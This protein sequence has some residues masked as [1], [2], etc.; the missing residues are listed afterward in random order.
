[1][2]VSASPSPA[3]KK[4]CSKGY[5]CSASCISRDKNCLS[6][7]AGD[8]SGFAGYLKRISGLAKLKTGLG[9]KIAQLRNKI[10]GDPEN[11]P[12]KR[13]G[14][15]EALN[16][17]EHRGKV[18]HDAL[19]LPKNVG[20]VENRDY[21]PDEDRY[22][23]KPHFAIQN[24]AQITKA[25]GEAT[26][27]DRSES[28]Q[29]MV[30]ANKWSQFGYREI[31]AAQQGREPDGGYGEFEGKQDALRAAGQLDRYIENAPKYEGVISRGLEFKS[32]REANA[33]I[34]GLQRSGTMRMDTLSSWTTS[35]GVSQS[36]GTNEKSSA[37]ILHTVNRQNGAS[38]KQLSPW[39]E[40]EVLCKTGSSY[41]VK[42]MQQ[43]RVGLLR[44]RV[45]WD[46]ILEEQ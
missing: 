15:Y 7:L 14:H 37:V 43:R 25:I 41:A 11:Q 17:D 28:R 34:L 45:V 6:K 46:V 10:F 30:D 12:I 22:K 31:R 9:T 2:P 21:D 18:G 42:S 20:A 36:Y 40:A 5:A 4:A 23:G 32:A 33:L 19:P 29:T 26:G 39:S 38:I 13:Y 27:F 24:H 8:A 35:T 44:N 1:M 3:S 16:P